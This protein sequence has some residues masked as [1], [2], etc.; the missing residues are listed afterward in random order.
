MFYNLPKAVYS[1]NIINE[2]CGNKVRGHKKPLY[3]AAQLCRNPHRV[4]RHTVLNLI[5]LDHN[6]RSGSCTP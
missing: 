6:T 2:L 5:Y 1:Y 4:L 3:T